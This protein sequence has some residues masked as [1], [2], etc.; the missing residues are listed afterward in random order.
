VDIQ[1]LSSD[2]KRRSELFSEVVSACK[3]LF[4]SAPE[5]KEVREYANNRLSNY[6]IDKYDVGFFPSN[7]DLSRLT[8]LVSREA[9]EELR[10]IYSKD[11]KE[12]GYCYSEDRGMFNV[13]NLIFP[14]KDEYGNII[15]LA[16]R[17]LLSDTEQKE[18]SVPKYK[19][20]FYNKSIHLF[21]LY[22][23]KG[24]IDRYDSA[25]IVEGQVDCISCH[26]HGFFN[27]VA[28][29]GSELTTY[30]V[31]LLKKM[32][33]KMYLLLDNDVAGQV[34]ASKIINKYSDYIEIERINL[35]SGFKDV[36]E[37]LSVS[38]DI[39]IFDKCMSVT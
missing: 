4:R 27:T 25:I 14:F 11:V 9:M 24:A 10:L 29:T 12:R 36:D 19:N 39:S 13:H 22:H 37:Y 34:A 33:S 3:H 38:G 15:A 21:G 16:G 32:A 7:K 23:T 28:L 1:Q 2:I 6:I 35:P 20:T 26:A 8:A 17:T 5:A 30:Q 31:F 18:L